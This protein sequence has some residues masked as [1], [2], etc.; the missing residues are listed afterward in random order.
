MHTTSSQRRAQNRSRRSMHHARP[1]QPHNAQ[2]NARRRRQIAVG[3][4]RVTG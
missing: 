2:E 3:V 1:A 4:I